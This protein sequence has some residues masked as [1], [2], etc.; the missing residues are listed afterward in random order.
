MSCQPLQ[1]PQGEMPVFEGRGGSGGVVQ[2]HMHS[3]IHI[4]SMHFATETDL[5][6][7]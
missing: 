2:S 3:R 7:K 1:L 5:K 4:M 6:P